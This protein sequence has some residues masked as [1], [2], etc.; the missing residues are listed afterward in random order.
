MNNRLGLYIGDLC[1][2]LDDKTWALLCKQME[3]NNNWDSYSGPI[4][5]SSYLNDIV[6]EG[7]GG[8]G[9]FSGYKLS[10]FPVDSGTFGAIW[11]DR[12]T[13]PDGIQ[14]G[15]VYDIDG[16]DL[17]N[18]P[19]LYIENNEGKLEFFV[20]NKLVEVIN[21]RPDE[22][23]EDEVYDDNWCNVC[24]QHYDDCCCSYYDE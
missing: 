14:F 6:I 11:V 23:E 17:E 18:R 7:T 10:V 15:C 13:N 4:P 21:I 5:H 24:M 19:R 2:V 22:T 1:Y 12:I 16:V 8:D 20:G 3:E 9:V